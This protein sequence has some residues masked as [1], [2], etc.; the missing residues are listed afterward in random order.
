MAALLSAAALFSSGCD[1]TLRA[2][3]ENGVITAS[4]S[5]FASFLQ[6]VIQLNEE[7][8]DPNSTD[9]NSTS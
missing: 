1:P 4:Q 5:L 3:V 7:Q 8:N 2:T 9:P 6:A